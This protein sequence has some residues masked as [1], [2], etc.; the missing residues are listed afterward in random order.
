MSFMSRLAGAPDE[1]L[2]DAVRRN[3]QAVLDAKQGYTGAVEVLG[4]GSYDTYAADKTLLEALVGEML[5]QV[6]R[7]EP[8]LREPRLTLL[9]RD[10]ALWV[11]FSLRGRLAEETVTFS[12]RF[13]SVFRNVLVTH[14]TT[15]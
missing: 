14:D 11:R 9:G 12:V 13:H 1:K 8:R 4:M 15:K 10:A 2:I 5:D 6:R 3:L 7:H